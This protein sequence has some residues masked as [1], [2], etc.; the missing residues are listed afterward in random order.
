MERKAI[1]RC[2]AGVCRARENDGLGQREG[3]GISSVGVKG[4]VRYAVIELPDGIVCSWVNK[5]RKDLFSS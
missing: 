5:Q 4:K 1:R 2:G 3:V